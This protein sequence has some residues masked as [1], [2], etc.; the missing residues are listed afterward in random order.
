M[1]DIG[2]MLLPS[3]GD[4]IASSH[5][6]DASTPGNGPN[7]FPPFSTSA[8]SSDSL[9]T[10][11]RTSSGM[12]SA[13]RGS[14]LLGMSSNTPHLPFL[15][16][17][18]EDLQ[19]DSVSDEAAVTG[20]EEPRQ[21]AREPKEKRGGERSTKGDKGRDEDRCSVDLSDRLSHHCPHAPRDEDW[22]G[23]MDGNY[24]NS[25]VTD[26]K[27]AT[28]YGDTSKEKGSSLAPALLN[29]VGKNRNH[30]SKSQDGNIESISVENQTV[31]VGVHSGTVLAASMVLSEEKERE[32][33]ERRRR[34]RSGGGGGLGAE[35]EAGTVW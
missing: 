3:N 34:R 13:R 27:S 11:R 23:N 30:P 21:Q 1:T 26:K 35:G 15:D 20:N 7:H 4:R 10:T 31:M 24:E 6:N 9:N 28:N 29:N 22:C 19:G 2:S 25:N 5:A 8:A 32:E 18:P 14:S 17:V 33:D 16:P 12:G